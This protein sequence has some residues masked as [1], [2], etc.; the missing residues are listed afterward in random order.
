MRPPLSQPQQR[1]LLPLQSGPRLILYAQTHHTPSGQPISLL[2]LLT[3]N[4]GVTHIYIAAIHLNDRPGD[5]TLN[6]HHPDD[7]RYNQLWGEV[8]WLQGAGVTVMGMLGGAAKGTF[9]RL[10]GD[11]E[12]FEHFYAPLHHLITSR[13]LQG[14]DLDIE[15]PVQ[16]TPILRL[17]RRLR[18]DFGPSFTLTMAPVATAML[19]LF[20]HLSGPEFS[21]FALESDA[22]TRA[23]L[24]WYNVQ[25]YCGWGDAGNTYL[26][27][28]ITSSGWR[29]G[30]IVLGVVTNPGN[31]AGHVECERLC[32]VLEMLRRR[33]GDGATAADGYAGFGGVM[34]WEYF[35]SGCHLPGVGEPWRWV[36]RLGRSVRGVLEP[37]TMPPFAPLP[38]PPVYQPAGAAA[39]PAPSIENRTQAQQ[40]G[41]SWNAARVLEVLARNQ[42]GTQQPSQL[43]AQ[44]PAQPRWPA[45]TVEKLTE[46]GFPE[47]QVVAALNA[48]GGNVEVAAGM[49]FEQ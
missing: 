33:F 26:Y 10:S 43:Q 49:L 31:G 8:A 17:L 5:I 1:A 47:A 39:V 14:L 23:L 35:N 40:G 25:F 2:P 41:G 9:E 46:L 29:P 19:P 30:R 42:T 37:I 27:E 38:P 12:S 15:E 34:G 4:T 22:E 7:A 24:S 11:E 18:H 28:A 20:P 21:Y 13:R 3:N 44:R 36:Q 6:D 45:E 32:G 16:H 48:A